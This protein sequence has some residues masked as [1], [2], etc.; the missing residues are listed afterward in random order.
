MDN[1]GGMILE[2]KKIH[3]DLVKKLLQMIS[4]DPIEVSLT[5]KVEIIIDKTIEEEIK[6]E[7]IETEIKE[8]IEAKD[9]IEVIETTIDDKTI[10]IEEIEDSKDNN[11]INDKT[12]VHLDNNPNK[13]NKLTNKNIEFFCVFN[14]KYYSISSKLIFFIYEYS[15][16]INH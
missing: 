5:T 7:I 2:I 10:T 14:F 1:K 8:T 13:P 9:N 16:K 11:E 3:R 4:T 12:V 6:E 15:L